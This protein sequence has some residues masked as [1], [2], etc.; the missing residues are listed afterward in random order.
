MCPH[1]PI[2]HRPRWRIDENLVSH[3]G[4]SFHMHLLSFPVPALIYR[5]EMSPVACKSVSAMDCLERLFQYNMEKIS[6]IHRFTRTTP[7]TI[8][9]S[10]MD[11]VILLDVVKNKLAVPTV[12]S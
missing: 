12:Y 8:Y 10:L 6:Y 11:V 1:H 2:R 7:C 5:P 3:V 4:S 9:H